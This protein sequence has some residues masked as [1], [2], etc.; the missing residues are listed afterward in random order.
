MLVGGLIPLGG[1]AFDLPALADWDRNGLAI[2]PNAAV[3]AVLT[4][5]ALVVLGAGRRRWGAAIGLAVVA[6][7][8]VTILE[9]LSGLDSGVDRL[10]LFG[11]T[12]GST[13]TRS[14]GR[15]GP[16]GSLCW[17]LIG[18]GLAATA[19][20]RRRRRAVPLLG[21]AVVALS[22]LS[23][24]GYVVGAGGLYAV[25]TLTVI[26]LQTSSFLFVSGL[27]L[28]SS[29][30]A[31]D[32]MRTM[33]EDSAAGL[34]ARRALPLAFVLPVTIAFL[35]GLG[36]AA[37]HY[38]AAMAMALLVVVLIVMICAVL[39]WG[40]VAV[41][42]RERALTVANARLTE[43]H[44][45][46]RRSEARMNA[47]L[48]QLPMGVGMFDGDGRWVY[49]NPM[50]DRF[51]RL[52]LPA[53]DPAQI[54]RWR[55]WDESGTPIGRADWPSAR[56][57]RGETVTGMEF[58]HTLDDGQDIWTRITAAPFRDHDGA[59]RGAMAIVQDIDEQKRAEEALASAE[60][61]LRL[62]TDHVP[63]L[64]A[65]CDH[66]GRYKFVNKAYADGSAS[67]PRRWSDAVSTN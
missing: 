63:V 7:A 18:L 65:Q 9:H 31:W 11:R 54:A 4:G 53:A 49:G 13:G 3:A 24:V 26:A 48:Q 64:I 58:L 52:D 60:R 43:A 38:D 55:I 35:L 19:T 67:H 22:G 16:P 21:L 59:I 37:G 41:R 56:A 25:P 14:P 30:R 46:L 10:L 20:R 6:I 33:L 36:T 5:V 47:F 39:W 29:A 27:G 1:W 8:G 23:L 32:P 34:L 45:S 50:L 62:V 17:L 42:N 15:M 12:W 40:V 66:A 57:L 51:V 44:S 2:Q 28:L 61:Q